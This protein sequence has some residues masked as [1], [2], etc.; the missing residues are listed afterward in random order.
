MDKGSLNFYFQFNLSPVHEVLADIYKD[1]LLKAELMKI[2][3]SQ[4]K[5]KENDALLS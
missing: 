3:I 5:K 4:K 1:I 2:L